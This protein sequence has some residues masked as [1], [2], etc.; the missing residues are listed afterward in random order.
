MRGERRET[1]DANGRRDNFGP[2]AKVLK[3]T[4]KSSVARE[5]SEAVGDERIAWTFERGKTGDYK[6][7]RRE[8]QAHL[9][10]HPEPF[11]IYDIVLYVSICIGFLCIVHSYVPLS[12]R[13]YLS[14]YC[15]D[16]QLIPCPRY[17]MSTRATTYS[18]VR[19]PYLNDTGAFS[20]R[21]TVV[22]VHA[23]VSSRHQM[24][25]GQSKRS[26]NSLVSPPSRSPPP[27]CADCTG[28]PAP[29]PSPS[30]GRLWFTCVDIHPHPESIGSRS[31]P[32]P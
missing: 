4:G 32:N 9:V 20:V 1:R 3:G 23:L 30:P 2:R 28:S 6:D 16:M 5:W 27:R 17:G 15:N 29:P 12:S 25:D 22:P 19:V 21:Y 13:M 31:R 26:V 10:R 24:L 11:F 7:W 14:S 8:F 18:T